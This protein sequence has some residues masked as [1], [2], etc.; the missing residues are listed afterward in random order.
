MASIFK[1]FRKVMT[2]AIMV[3]IVSS[4]VVSAWATTI[5]FIDY[6]TSNTQPDPRLTPT[7]DGGKFE[8]DIKDLDPIGTVEP[9][10]FSDQ[11][12]L[13]L[14]YPSPIRPVTPEPSTILLFG[15]GLFGMIVSFVRRTYAATKRVL[16]I[17]AGII[18]LVVLSPLFLITAIIIRIGSKGPIFYKQERVGKDGKTFWIYKFR[19]MKV[20]AEKETGPVWASE[21]DN[22]IIPCGKFLRKAHVDEIPQF[23]N[24]LKGEMSL[25]GPRP[26]RPVF[27]KKFAQEIPEYEKRLLVKPGLTGLAQVWHRYD[28]TIE[29]VKKKIKYDLLYIKKICLWTDLRIFFR[30]FRV[31]LTG[32]G[33]R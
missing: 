3:A 24:I 14:P 8:W 18:G 17:L 12:N 19:T 4:F 6:S 31:V 32:E 20:D 28:E 16:D 25:V 13:L 26:E 30:T 22:R 9:I 1:N 21:N 29:D 10:K 23:I 7:N 33:A 27:V 11:R 15:G 2:L 5:S